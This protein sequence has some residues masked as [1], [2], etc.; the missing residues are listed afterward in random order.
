MKLRARFALLVAGTIAVPLLVTGLVFTVRVWVASRSEPVPNYA[1]IAAWLRD[2]PPEPRQDLLKVFAGRRPIGVEL[3]AMDAGERVLFSTIPVFPAG[4]RIDEALLLD[5]VRE[6]ADRFHFQFESPHEDGDRPLLLLQLL[7]PPRPPFSFL[8]SRT[9][10]AAAY[11]LI[12][13]VVFS[14]LVSFLFARYLNRSIIT[15]EEATRRIAGGDLDFRLV[16]R[17]SDEV[18]SL[19]RSFDGMRVALREEQ[20]RRARFIMGVSHDLKTP[21]SLIQGYVEAI[22]DGLAADPNTRTRYLAVI[23]EKTKSLEG[24]IGELIDFARLDTGEWKGRFQ[25]VPIRRFLL[26]LAAR[27]REDA[28][29][30][31]REFKA[32]IDVP[33]GVSVP[34]EENTCTRALENL[35]G[36]AL[37][38]TAED[39]T[40]ELSAALEGN[41]VVVSVSDTGVGIPE[42]E[43]PYIFDPFF[44]GTNSRREQGS[45]L[46]LSTVKSI[47]ESHGWSITV[48]SAVGRGTAFVI[49]MSAATGS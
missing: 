49:R 45:G 39:G 27:F 23:L 40:V 12:A 13:L 2:I 8:R 32:R 21:L 1:G 28:A 30:L 24:M 44:R 42:R 9:L 34:M 35:I 26:S 6:N 19:T 43:L 46:G 17:G 29:L 38:Y 33:D 7:R 47:V 31:K 4:R 41:E 22:A 18:A 25:E 48:S 11:G 36:N 37:R 10:M 20:A 5:Y 16:A 3:I 14:A 15:L